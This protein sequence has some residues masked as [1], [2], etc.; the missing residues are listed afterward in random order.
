MV[1]AYNLA[2][3]KPRFRRV[4]PVEHLQAHGTAVHVGQAC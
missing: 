4:D 3:R 1:K 2:N